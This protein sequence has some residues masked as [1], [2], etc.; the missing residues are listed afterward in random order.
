MTPE[1]LKEQALHLGPRQAL[2]GILTPPPK[3]VAPRDQT[4]V[5]LNS[6][7][8][9]RVGAN[10]L[11]VELARN[12]A[13]AGFRVLRFDLSGIGDSLPRASQSGDLLETV[14]EDIREAI[15]HVAGSDGRVALFGLCSGASHALLYAPRDERVNGLMLLDLWIP[16]TRGYHM[17]RAW[18]RISR[19]RGWLNLIR[20]RHPLIR[21][22]TA[23]L[24]EGI[25]HPRTSNGAAEPEPTPTITIE[26]A[27]E[28]LASAFRPLLARNV[29]M[30]AVFTAGLE[31]Q[32]NYGTQLLD[33]FPDIDF[34]DR[35]QLE[36]FGESDHTFTAPVHRR[37]LRDIVV[38]WVLS[39]RAAEPTGKPDRTTVVVAALCGAA[40]TFATSF[41]PSRFPR[42]Y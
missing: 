32:H 13:R 36:W 5:M 42:F 37:R 31:D 29:P 14:M 24:H 12:L 18:K 4:I 10:R 25:A 22:A 9:H 11:H 40:S 7:V 30:L 21:R 26:Q 6:G 15:D 19:R 33:A 3:G 39:A 41:D 20:L 35:V 8:I 23:L 1:P 34:G 28:M 38:S 2:V 16:H 27:R 17:R